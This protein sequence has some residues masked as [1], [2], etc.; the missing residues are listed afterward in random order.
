MSELDKL[1]KKRLELV[2][3]LEAV[4]AEIR[5]KAIE[6][7]TLAQTH[8]TDLAYSAARFDNLQKDLARLRGQEA[9]LRFDLEQVEL[10]INLASCPKPDPAAVK[11]QMDRDTRR[12]ELE[13]HLARV[14]VD[15]EAKRAGLGSAIVAGGDPGAL[16]D[17]LSRLELQERALLSGLAELKSN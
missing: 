1:N 8:R 3:K 12:L 5:P 14:R 10:K 4:R 11:Q 2:E 13:S 9:D 16:M 15:L 6:F 17:E 7:G